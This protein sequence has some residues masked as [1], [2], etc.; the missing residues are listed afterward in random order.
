[1]S[2]RV[3]APSSQSAAAK[4]HHTGIWPQIAFTLEVTEGV[5]Q[6]LFNDRCECFRGRCGRKACRTGPVTNGRVNSV[7]VAGFGDRPSVHPQLN[8]HFIAIGDQAPGKSK[9]E[10]GGKTARSGVSNVAHIVESYENFSAIGRWRGN[11]KPRRP[12]HA[13]DMRTDN[14]I[15]LRQPTAV[16]AGSK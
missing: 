7:L 16:S 13:L 4:R 10:P 5:K 9:R 1:M 6:H 3:T 11:D 8:T 15:S 12:K 2:T 14:G